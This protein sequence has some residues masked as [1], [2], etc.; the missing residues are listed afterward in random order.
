MKILLI[1]V[2][3][4]LTSCASTMPM[5]KEVLIPTV[6]PCIAQLPVSPEFLTNEQLK[7]VPNNK[8]AIQVTI[9][10]LK[11]RSYIDELLAVA[12]PCL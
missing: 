2:L 12:Q 10:L 8:Y 11:S 7:A 5:P 9:E 6:A 3:F 4:L 1:P